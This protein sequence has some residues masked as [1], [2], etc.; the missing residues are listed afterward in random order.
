MHWTKAI[1]MSRRRI[2]SVVLVLLWPSLALAATRINLDDDW[3]FRIDPDEA[4]QQL[5]W[6]QT[7][8]NGCETVSLPHT[9]NIG[10]HEDYE[11]QAWYFKRVDIPKALLGQ[12]LELHFG[13][14]FYKARVWMNGAE[15]GE[16]EGGYTEYFF[17]ITKQARANNYLAVE[18]DNRPGV[19]TI[20]GWAMRQLPSGNI[21]YDWWHYGGIVRDVWLT[22]NHDVLL[23]RQQIRSHVQAGDAEVSNRVYLENLGTHSRRVNIF[24]SAL[25]EDGS[26]AAGSELR[27]TVLHPGSN[28]IPIVLH[29]SSPKLWSFD[30]PNT[31][32]MKVEVFDEHN[33]PL[34]SKSDTFG[35]RTIEIKDRHLLL[36]GQRVRLTGVTRHEETPWEGLAESRGSMLR[37]YEEMK[38]LHVTLTRP[39]HYPQNPYILDLA[40]RMG[41]LLIPEIPVWQ[42]SARQLADPKVRALA[43][44]MMREMIEQAGN[45]PSIFAWSVCNESETA[46]PEGREYIRQMKAMIRELDPDRFVTFADL[47]MPDISRAEDSGSSEADFIMMNEYFGTWAGPA[48]QLST[49]L[50]KVDRLFPDKMAVI[51]EF[52]VAGI[53]ARNATEADLLRVN[54]INTQLPELERRDWIGGAIFWCY[55]DYKSH[56]NLWPGQTE[57]YVDHGL[58]DENRQ[59]RPSFY[60]WKELNAPATIKAE[61]TG[62]QYSIPNGFKAAVT[63]RAYSELPSYPMRDYRLRWEVRDQHGELVASGDRALESLQQPDSFTEQWVA[64]SDLTSLTLR[65]MLL[66]PTGDT[67]AEETNQWLLVKPGGQGLREL[68]ANHL[69]Y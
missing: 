57:G 43:K 38:S 60:V 14:T 24:L 13:A 8:P 44:Q 69:S 52:G 33:E 7:T 26:T 49:V 1:D 56:R 62:P 17:D 64:K 9:W 58:V 65:V 5:G 3:H 41:I 45:H 46:T 51:S 53:F 27:E 67:A 29:L 59:R 36:N 31:Y 20:P 55:Q 39:V 30:H 16:H 21:W 66:S 50:D 6:M 32:E 28:E 15:L 47:D 63:K 25:R 68:H 23:R 19:A 42:F 11:G 34:D 22:V 12:H 35:T 37:D 4:G 54:V 40:D 10:A 48:S 2:L 18:I 61:F